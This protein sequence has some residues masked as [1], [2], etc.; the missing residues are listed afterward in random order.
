MSAPENPAVSF[1]STEIS[2]GKPVLSTGKAYVKVTTLNG[3][4]KEG[5]FIFNKNNGWVEIKNIKFVKGNIKTYNLK[6]VGKYNNFFAEDFL[7]H[8]KGGWC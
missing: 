6:K 7:V 8:N 5:D 3:P 2:N 1:E 4:I